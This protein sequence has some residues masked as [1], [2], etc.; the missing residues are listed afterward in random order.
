MVYEWIKAI[1]VLAVISWMAGLLYLPRLMVYH[2]GATKGEEF[3]ETLKVMERRLLKAIMNPAMLVSW[4][5]GVWLAWQVGLLHDWPVWFSVKVVCLVLMTGFHMWLAGQVKVFAS[6]SNQRGHISF[7][8]AN[9]LP[10]V[11]MVLIVVMVIVK[12]FQ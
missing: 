7:R 4:I 10:T 1:H 12:P 2:C 6:D 5:A 3:S 8:V 11:L 9:E